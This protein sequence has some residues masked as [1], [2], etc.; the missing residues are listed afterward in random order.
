M[1]SYQARCPRRGR[2]WWGFWKLKR[3]LLVLGRDPLRV[4]VASDAP[5]GVEFLEGPLENPVFTKRSWPFSH[6]FFIVL[7]GNRGL[8]HERC[9]YKS[10]KNHDHQT[11]YKTKPFFYMYVFNGVGVDWWCFLF[12]QTAWGRSCS[13]LRLLGS[14]VWPTASG[15]GVIG[16]GGLGG[17]NYMVVVFAMFW[18]AFL[19]CWFAIFAMCLFVFF[20]CLFVC[21]HACLLACYVCGFVCSFVCLVGLFVC[22]SVCLLFRPWVADYPQNRG[23]PWLFFGKNMFVS[24]AKVV[25]F[26]HRKIRPETDKQRKTLKQKTTSKCCISTSTRK[27]I[28]KMWNQTQEGKRTRTKRRPKAGKPFFVFLFQFFFLRWVCDFWRLEVNK[29]GST[30]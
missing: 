1:D 15:S 11:I 20:A 23:K 13:P 10:P 27:D 26:N 16:L 18:F 5:G 8:W 19:L 6:V 25:S 9:P 30:S 2:L 3:G 4:P 17:V 28:K 7:S 21:L 24:I 29:F 12:K 22:L 14:S